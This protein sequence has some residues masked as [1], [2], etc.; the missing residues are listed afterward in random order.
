MGQTLGGF[1]NGG[2]R[3]RAEKKTAIGWSLASSRRRRI[4]RNRRSTLPISGQFE[5]NNLV[6]V[7]NFFRH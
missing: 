2:G 3:R 5:Q 6:I 7:V 1:T 4:G